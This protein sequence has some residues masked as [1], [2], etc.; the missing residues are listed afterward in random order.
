VSTLRCFLCWTMI[1]VVPSSLLGQS[2]PS[3][4]TQAPSPAARAQ[5]PLAI[6]HTQ[7]GVWINGY[8]ATDSSAVFAGD[9]LETKTGFAANMTLEGTTILLQQ[10]S[11]AKLQEDVLALDHGSVSV[12][13]S[14]N[15]KVRV[16]CI[17]VVPV[18]S[19]WTQ[20][21]VTDVNGTVEVAARKD[22]VRVELGLNRQKTPTQ[23]D[24]SS[25]AT[26]H[27]GEQGKYSESKACGAPPRLPGASNLNPKWIAA[28]GAA[29]G[30]IL[31]CVLL[32]GGGGKSP[33]SP[34]KP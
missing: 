25:D 33:V 23:P 4:A 16:N 10:G 24:T 28:G 21:D 27:E 9:L 22:D 3:P 31:L 8:E 13:T 18:H 6:L 34:E 2:A 15:F 7:G 5:T 11:V 19:A 32:C 29:A 20:Y 26:V 30:G 1:V 14:K 12:G 17:T